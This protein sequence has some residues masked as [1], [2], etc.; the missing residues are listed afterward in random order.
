M[1]EVLAPLLLFVAAAAFAD[2]AD[3]AVRFYFVDTP[4]RPGRTSYFGIAVENAGPALARYVIVAVRIN[5]FPLAWQPL[6]DRGPGNKATFVTS[7]ALPSAD[8]TIT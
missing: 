8:G 4:N 3:L 5:G 2:S 1:R 6:G 7:T